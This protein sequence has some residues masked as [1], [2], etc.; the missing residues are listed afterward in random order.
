MSAS[1]SRI[2]LA[3]GLC[4]ALAFGIFLARRPVHEVQL[5]FLAVGQ[6]D[7][8][9]LRQGESAILIDTGPTESAARFTILITW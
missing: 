5:V 8:A 3:I 9:I 6:G 2:L 4:L 7:C 1:H